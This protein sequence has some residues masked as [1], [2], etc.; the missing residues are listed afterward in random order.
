MG[1]LGTILRDARARIQA[2]AEVFWA[3]NE[4]AKGEDFQL[5]VDLLSGLLLP[6]ATAY[7]RAVLRYRQTG[8]DADA[9]AAL[10]LAGLPGAHLQFWEWLEDSGLQ[11]WTILEFFDRAI[12]RAGRS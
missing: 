5:A 6:T 4:A 2:G 8:L 9:K 11:Q 10:Q 12:L 7:E 3:L 1:N